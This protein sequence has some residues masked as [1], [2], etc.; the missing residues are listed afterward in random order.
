MFQSFF[1]RSVSPGII[2]LFFFSFC[3]YRFRKSDQFFRGFI[4][5]I[6][7]VEDYIFAEVPQMWVNFIIHHQLACIYNT[8]IHTRFDS[9]E[10]EYRVHGFPH[11]FIT[12]EREGEVAYTATYFRQRHQFF[13]F[14]GGFNKINSVIIMFLQPRSYSKNIWIEYDILRVITH[15]LCQYFISTVADFHFSVLCISLPLFIKSHH[16][17]RCPI[18][19]ANDGLFNE[20]RFPFFHGDRIHNTFSLHTF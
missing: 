20:F 4:V 9:I 8:H 5:I 3:F 10:Q 16:D 19:L 18:A 7:A 15:L 2:F 11:M 17:H 14:P 13:Y 6:I 1:H 12:A